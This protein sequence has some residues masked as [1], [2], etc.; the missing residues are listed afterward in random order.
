MWIVVD[1]G[2]IECGE[3]SEI[4]GIFSD[5]VRA[6]GIAEQLNKKLPFTHGQHSYV[7]FPIPVKLD[8][9]HPAY[10]EYI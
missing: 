7:V 3:A 6:D 2:C 10:L 8:E 5:K 9:V 4:V 1:I